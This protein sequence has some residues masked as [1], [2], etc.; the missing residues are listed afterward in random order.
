M[1]M[2]GRHGFRTRRVCFGALV[3]ALLALPVVAPAAGALARP[4]AAPMGVLRPSIDTTRFTQ[5]AKPL[6][7]PEH[8]FVRMKPALRGSGLARIAAAPAVVSTKSVAHTSWTVV[9]TVAGEAGSTAARLARDPAVADVAPSY[10]RKI[11]T[12]PNDPLFSSKQASYLN[13][14]RMD[15]VWDIAK[16]AGVTVAVLDSGVDLDHPDLAGQLVTGR[17]ILNPAKSVQDDNG[18]GTMTAGIVV[19]KRGNGRGISGIAPSAKVM[20]IK[21]IDGDGFGSDADIAEGLDWA[22]SHGADVVNMSLGSAAESTVLRDAVAAAIAADVVVVAASGNEASDVPN[23]PAS[24]PGVISVGATGHDGSLAYFS[25][26]GWTVDV[27]APGMAITSTGLGSTEKY[28]TGDGTSF[29]SPIVAGV[30]ALLLGHG[31]AAEDVADQIRST[32]RDMGANGGDRFYGRGFVDPLAALGGTGLPPAPRMPSGLDEPNDIRDSATS[33]SPGVA[34]AASIGYEGDVDWYSIHLP[35]GWYYPDGTIPNSGGDEDPHQFFPQIKLYDGDGNFMW[36]FLSNLGFP[37][38]RVQV[39]GDYLIEFSNRFGSST[40]SFNWQVVSFTDTVRRFGLDGFPVGIAGRSTAVADVTGDGRNDVITSLPE[41]DALIVMAQRPDRSRDLQQV[42]LTDHASGGGM[43]A[44]DL[45]GDDDADVA[46]PTADGIDFFA[47]GPDGLEDPELIA[48]GLVAAQLAV[49]DVDGDSANDLVAA[50]SFGVKTL[51]GPAF[52]TSTV[53]TTRGTTGGIA[54][55]DVT[56][57]TKP[58]VVTCCAEN[59]LRIYPRNAAR[60][61][62]PVKPYSAPSGAG[63]AIGEVTGDANNDVVVTIKKAMPDTALNIYPGNGSGGVSAPVVKKLAQSGVGPVAIVDANADGKR[64]IV[65][66]HDATTKAVMPG[67]FDVTPGRA[68][69]VRG[70]GGTSYANEERFN[71]FPDSLTTAKP[72]AARALA[73]GDIDS[74]G[75]ADIVVADIAGPMWLIQNSGILP[76]LDPAW[77]RSGAPEGTPF[78]VDTAVHPSIAFGRTM[79]ETTLSANAR[80]L[81]R[82]GEAV[83]I[84]LG[85]DG[86][87]QTLGVAPDDPLPA[88]PYSLRVDG[89]EDED[90]NVYNGDGLHFWVGAKPDKT[91]PQTTITAK[92]ASSTTSSAANFSFTSSEGGSTFLCSLDNVAMASCSS[93]SLGSVAKGTHTF[94]VL[95]I[96]PTGNEDV[97]PATYTWKRT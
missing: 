67:I 65:V 74:D 47:Q 61:F 24:Y 36:S 2:H 12:I 14:L 17:N 87:T 46:L 55:G 27:A 13:G 33:I 62:S 85:F 51:W 32:A 89:A 40:G 76:T 73:T 45:D 35:P 16:G 91:A 48:P 92:P 59:A 80:L 7:D 39:E 11:S 34:R 29:A 96:D 23:Y 30:A 97:T 42:I 52:S 72:Y 43:V 8:V 1:Q 63:V 66:L 64:D 38:F 95:A 57:D 77:L 31:T 75:R 82:N 6:L 22:V 94:R 88:G 18:H 49:A 5:P 93:P 21:V 81:D 86:G 60:T 69:F 15:R 19:A 10:L 41:I 37:A 71:L 84:V 44:G 78:N 28:E 3:V 58:D 83:A 79:N 4:A 56:G 20:P 53:V 9:E 90:G 68:G 26:Y 54:V 25:S 50:G 70:L